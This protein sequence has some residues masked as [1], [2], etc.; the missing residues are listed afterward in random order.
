MQ[1][2]GGDMFDELKERLEDLEARI[3]EL[4]GYL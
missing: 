3:V 4:R 2:E 1:G